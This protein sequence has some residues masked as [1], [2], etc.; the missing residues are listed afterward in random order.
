[1][2]VNG[3]SRWTYGICEGILALPSVRMHE[4]QRFLGEWHLKFIAGMGEAWIGSHT[5]VL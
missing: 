5:I 1:M 4:R 3:R 2:G